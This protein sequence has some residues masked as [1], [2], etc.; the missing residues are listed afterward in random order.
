[1]VSNG[2]SK[3]SRDGRTHSLSLI[4]VH[5]EDTQE[6]PSPHFRYIMFVASKTFILICVTAQKLIATL[7]AYSLK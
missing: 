2:Y 4:L 7:S 3:L 5:T 1:M 6:N